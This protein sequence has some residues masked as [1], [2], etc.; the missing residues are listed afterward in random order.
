MN[1]IT[2][3]TGRTYN[4]PQTLVITIEQETPG[5]FDEEWPGLR[6]IVATFTDA[7][8]RISGRVQTIIFDQAGPDALAMLVLSQYDSGAYVELCYQEATHA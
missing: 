3:T 8:R 6:T 2:Y 4:G 1:T 5:M 7:S